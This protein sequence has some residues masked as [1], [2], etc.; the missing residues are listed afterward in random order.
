MFSFSFSNAIS[1]SKTFFFLLS[2]FFIEFQQK[3]RY[4]PF[5]TS[6]KMRP[7]R[8]ALNKTCSSVN[9][10]FTIINKSERKVFG[11]QIIFNSRRFVCSAK[12]FTIIDCSLF[13]FLFSVGE[14]GVKLRFLL[15][16][17]HLILVER[18]HKTSSFSVALNFFVRKKL[19]CCC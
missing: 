4:K 3:A 17:S 5:F 2:F 13:F 15:S 8:A 7:P 18:H 14:E 16:E 9:Y 12:C 11:S 1:F 19:V 6:N 10:C